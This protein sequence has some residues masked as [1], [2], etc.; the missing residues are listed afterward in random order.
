MAWVTMCQA[1]GKMAD[2]TIDGHT[3]D[4]MTVKEFKEC[5]ECGG[6]LDYD[7]MGDLVKDGQIVTPKG[8]EGLMPDWIYPSKRNTI[9]DDVT[10]ILWYNK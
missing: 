4:L 3:G 2:T 8:A 6:F 1:G 7:G 5:C 10:H 9:P